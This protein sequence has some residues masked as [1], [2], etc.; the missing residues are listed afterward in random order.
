VSLPGCAD[1]AKNA[2]TPH[3][4]FSLSIS[5][6]ILNIIFTYTNQKISWLSLQL[7]WQGSEMNVENTTG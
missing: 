6:D 4:A 2:N 3:D 7:H 1:E 5:D